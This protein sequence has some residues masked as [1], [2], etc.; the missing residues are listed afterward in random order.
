MYDMNQGFEMKR[1]AHGLRRFVSL[2]VGVKDF[3]V[4]QMRLWRNAVSRDKEKVAVFVS[5]ICVLCFFVSSVPEYINFANSN[6]L[7][8]MLFVLSNSLLFAASAVLLL[9]I[10]DGPIKKQVFKSVPIRWSELSGKSF[11][12]S[13]ARELAESVVRK[14]FSFAYLCS[15]FLLSAFGDDNLDPLVYLFE[16]GDSSLFF[17]SLALAVGYVVMLRFERNENGD[18]L[19]EGAE[20]HV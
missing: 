8:S 14:R 4:V 20:K 19:L 15:G 17:I 18:I 10:F 3:S 13:K 12:V 7:F 9:D 1:I 11:P 5:C 2:A 16:W 6:G